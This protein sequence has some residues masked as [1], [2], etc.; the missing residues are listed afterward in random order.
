MRA[1]RDGSNDQRWEK[2]SLELTEEFVWEREERVRVDMRADWPFYT[3][4]GRFCLIHGG[5]RSE[6]YPPST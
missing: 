5:M 1:G 2:I 3:G 4:K 6:V